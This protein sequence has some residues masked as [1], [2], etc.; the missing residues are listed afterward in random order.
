MHW[1]Q[2]KLLLRVNALALVLLMCWFVLGFAVYR[3][4]YG[5][6]V[7]AS[8]RAAVFFSHVESDFSYAYDKWTEGVVFGFIFSILM[9]NMI[10]KFNPERSC[11][12]LAKELS[13][14]IV[15]VGYSHLGER[16]VSFLRAKSIPYCLIERSTERIDDLLREGQPVIVDDARERD[17]LEDANVAQ[18]RAV[19]IASNNLETALLVTK[20]AREANKSCMILARCYQDDFA[21]VMESLGANEVISSS[22]NAFDDIVAR[23]KL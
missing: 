15:V 3:L 5:M 20:R 14:H 6:G 23:M 22:K 7:V 11:R 13:G 4:V 9:Q 12:M 18:A 10:D 16:I 17:A 8:L 2:A 19:L 1:I 21:E